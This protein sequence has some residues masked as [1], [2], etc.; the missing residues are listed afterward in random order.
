MKEKYYKPLFYDGAYEG[1]KRGR[2]TKEEKRIHNENLRLKV[3]KKT[4]ILS[5]D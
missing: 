2:K 1:K 3:V 4:I 5:F